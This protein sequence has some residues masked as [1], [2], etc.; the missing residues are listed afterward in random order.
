MV[1]QDAADLCR[2]PDRGVEHIRLGKRKRRGYERLLMYLDRKMQITDSEGMTIRFELTPREQ[3]L[4]DGLPT[5]VLLNAA[6]DGGGKVVEL[7]VHSGC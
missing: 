1:P 2:S 3:M 6:A 5:L 4:V 7:E